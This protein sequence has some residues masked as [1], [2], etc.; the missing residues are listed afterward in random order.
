MLKHQLLVAS[1]DQ[2]R[3]SSKVAQLLLHPL[4]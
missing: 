1:K 2:G 3:N 4:L